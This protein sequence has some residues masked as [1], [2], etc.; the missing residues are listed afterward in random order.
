MY[1]MM[2]Y[3]NVWLE[4]LTLYPTQNLCILRRFTNRFERGWRQGQDRWEKDAKVVRLCVNNLVKS[5]HKRCL[6]LQAVGQTN[7]LNIHAKQIGLENCLGKYSFL[8][9]KTFFLKATAF[10]DISIWNS[11]SKFTRNLQNLLYNATPY[12]YYVLICY[13]I[14][15]EPCSLIIICHFYQSLRTL[16][17]NYHK[18]PVVCVI[19]LQFQHFYNLIFLQE[20][21]LIHQPFYYVCFVQYD[22]KIKFQLCRKIKIAWVRAVTI[23]NYNIRRTKCAINVE[24]CAKR[25]FFRTQN[26]NLKFNLLTSFSSNLVSFFLLAACCTFTYGYNRA[27][28]INND[29]VYVNA[30]LQSWT[31]NWKGECM[32]LNCD[33]FVL[34]SFV[35]LGRM[36]KVR[37]SIWKN[38]Y[39]KFKGNKAPDFA[40]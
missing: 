28:G 8:F 22:L 30:S 13:M 16:S 10:L 21:R 27:E 12:D 35:S 40:R 5:R 3:N 23:T 31:K 25:E 37:W 36:L 9:Y 11:K 20:C 4:G 38:T 34:G 39:S 33:R 2:F 14:L 32:S 29:N 17:I 19:K 1:I 24:L 18:V 26:A 7:C 6:I 15:N